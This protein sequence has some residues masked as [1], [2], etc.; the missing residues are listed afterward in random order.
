MWRRYIL[1]GPI[2][3]RLY[4]AKCKR[5]NRGIFGTKLAFLMTQTR[6]LRMGY[7]FNRRH[8]DAKSSSSVSDGISGSS[9]VFVISGK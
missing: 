1:G 8:L 5:L 4:L 9:S 3:F 2:F 7:L 6:M